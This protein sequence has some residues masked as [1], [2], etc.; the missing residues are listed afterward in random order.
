MGEGD[1][2]RC[3]PFVSLI[4]VLSVLRVRALYIKCI[5]NDFPRETLRPGSMPV[6]LVSV[7]VLPL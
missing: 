7:S 5:S 6:F 2:T 4:P 1:K 3:F